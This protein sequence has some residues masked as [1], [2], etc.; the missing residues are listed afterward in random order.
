MYVGREKKKNRVSRRMRD[1]WVNNPKKGSFVGG[2]LGLLEGK[3]SH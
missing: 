2:L 3:K 1:I